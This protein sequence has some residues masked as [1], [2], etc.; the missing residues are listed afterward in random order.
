MTA[1]ED[2]FAFVV[3]SAR[4]VILQH[5]SAVAPSGR[6]VRRTRGSALRARIIAELEHYE[7]LLPRSETK[8][9]LSDEAGKRSA[10][11]GARS[12][13]VALTR[14]DAAVTWVEAGGRPDVQ[15]AQVFFA[16]EAGSAI[17]QRPCEV[18]TVPS[19]EFGYATPVPTVRWQTAPAVGALEPVVVFVPPHEQVSTLFLP[20]LAHEVSHSEV[21]R[22][23]QALLG[24]VKQR[25]GSGWAEA[26]EEAA[27]PLEAEQALGRDAAVVRAESRLER[28]TTEFLCDSFALAYCGPSYLYAFATVALS[29]ELTGTG[30]THPPPAERLKAMLILCDDLGWESSSAQTPVARWVN[31][32]AEARLSPLS[33]FDER[34]LRETIP[35]ANVVHR[36]VREHLGDAVLSPVAIE[37]M[38][39]AEIGDLLLAGV[40]PAQLRNGDGA[41]ARAIVHVAWQQV[42]AA[43][44]PDQLPEVLSDADYQRLLGRAIE[45]SYVV[46]AWGS[47]GG[48][49]S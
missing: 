21:E 47:G 10:L 24:R 43:R 37:H 7:S 19:A 13:G 17:L 44:R 5:R 27:G 14:L 49:S 30:E 38:H 11:L 29:R 25:R 18:V 35:I 20:L 33:D 9:A 15:F 41:H 16:E 28:W 8:F 1:V 4:R 45:L 3:A 36:I 6:I 48:G 32:A 39:V 42:T 46:D 2:D 40:L 22:E 26:V 23:D 12:I 34:L 31:A